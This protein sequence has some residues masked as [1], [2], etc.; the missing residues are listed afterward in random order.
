VNRSTYST[1]LEVPVALI[2]VLGYA[3]ICAVATIH[4]DN[5]DTPIILLMASVGGLGFALI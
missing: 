3:C 1:V 2:G 5:A 4:G